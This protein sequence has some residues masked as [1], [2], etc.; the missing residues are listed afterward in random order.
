VT[1][2]DVSGFPIEDAGKRF[3]ARVSFTGGVFL[4]GTNHV[5]RSQKGSGLLRRMNRFD[6]GEFR[7]LENLLLYR[8]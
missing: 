5:W 7:D 2:F 1:P 6:W 4:G 8:E 3:C